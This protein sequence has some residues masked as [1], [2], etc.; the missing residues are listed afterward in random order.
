[1]II[2]DTEEKKQ[3]FEQTEK[4]NNLIKRLHKLEQEIH[5]INPNIVITIS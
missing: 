1:M 3:I 2:F 4:L 5:E